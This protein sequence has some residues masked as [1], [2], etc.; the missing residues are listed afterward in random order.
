MRFMGRSA[1]ERGVFPLK[2]DNHIRVYCHE[3]AAIFR[4]LAVR[5]LA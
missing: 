5:E 3:S 1:A 4:D 2:G